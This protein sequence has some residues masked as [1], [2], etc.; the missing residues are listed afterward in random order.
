MNSEYEVEI[1]AATLY[2]IEYV[3][4]KNDKTISSIKWDC[5]IWN[6]FRGKGGIAHK[7]DTIFY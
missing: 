4:N 3:K 1:R 6:Y 2:V 7:T 5:I